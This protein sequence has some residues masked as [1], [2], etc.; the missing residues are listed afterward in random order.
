M[1]YAKPCPIDMI[2]RDDTVV[3]V[4][5]SFKPDVM[6]K[7]QTAT[8]IGTI[9]ID[10]HATAKDYGYLC[11]G[12]R[13][14]TNKGPSGCE[15]AWKFFFPND[16][17]P[18]AVNLIGDYDSWRLQITPGCFRLYE[19]LKMED[20]SPQSRLWH[21]LLDD[22]DTDAVEEIAEHGKACI[23]YRDNYC[24]D[25]V[26]SYGYETEIDG[27]RAFACNIFRFGSQS[28]GTKFTEYQ[29]CLAYIHD[30]KKFTVSLYSETVDVSAI[31]K[32]HGGGG[33]KGAA[34]FTCDT[35]PFGRKT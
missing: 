7:V 4:D 22:T 12:L 1:D 25:M 31:A 2:Q 3:I 13:D 20:Q 33:H 24:G 8:D 34:G 11:A 6:A 27:V 9:W 10:H 35:L 5:F 32:A 19:G 21:R 17:V 16:V 18:Q 15:L 14:F 28:F 23:A 26:K 30:G 29:I